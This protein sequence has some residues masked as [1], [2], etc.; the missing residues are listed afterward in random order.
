M[1]RMW[2]SRSA[3]SVLEEP[4]RQTD[5][6]REIAKLPSRHGTNAHCLPAHLT[7]SLIFLKILLIFVLLRLSDATAAIKAALNA[8]GSAAWKPNQTAARS[9]EIDL[10]SNPGTTSDPLLG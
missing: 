5:G 6:Q 8:Q 4:C 1:H 9:A 3:H 10:L 7:I 2:C